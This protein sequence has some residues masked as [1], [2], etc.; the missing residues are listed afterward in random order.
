[1]SDSEDDLFADDDDGA[2]AS[3]GFLSMFESLTTEAPKVEPTID[4]FAKLLAS[5]PERLAL[6][7]HAIGGTGAVALA[8][9][10]AGAPAASVTDVDLEANAIGDEGAEA[11]A[12]AC[13]AGAL[14]QLD[15]LYLTE[16][17]IGSAGLAS[18]A[19]A[20]TGNVFSQLS[21]LNLNSNPIGDDGFC[22]LGRAVA[23]GA[24]ASLSK[25][26]MDSG[27][28]GDV[29]LTGFA[30]GLAPGR[31]PALY[32][33][34]ISNNGVGDEGAS[35]LFRALSIG[36]MANLGD[37]RMQYNRVTDAGIAALVDCLTAVQFSVRLGTADSTADGENLGLHSLQPCR[38]L[39]NA[40]YLGLNDNLFTDAGLKMLERSLQ[41]GALP[42]LEFFTASSANSSCEAQES[43]QNVFTSRPR[44]KRQ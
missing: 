25:L 21:A 35:A 8:A 17:A 6:S 9:A 4:G 30:R 41:A 3:P 12:K 36:A 22:A 32:E 28:F 33:L 39:C 23:S 24:L 38:A 34:W 5:A 31:L 37:L 44:P 11:L 16:N 43:I 10:L 18:L 13:A 29:G 1:M 20:M 42:R 7:K 19:T 27:G 14:P 15:K 40:W 2:E 26:F